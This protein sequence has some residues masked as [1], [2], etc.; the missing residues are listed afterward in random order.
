M[1]THFDAASVQQ[2]FWILVEAL[3]ALILGGM[4]GLEREKVG[5][6][7]G[8]RTHML[9]CVAAMLFIRISQFLIEDTRKVLPVEMLSIDP[10]RMLEAIMAGIAFI[11]AGTVF[12][13]PDRNVMRGLTTAASLLVVVPIGVAV[14]LDR[15]VL[16]VGST[17]LV[18]VV[19]HA[20]R[21][22]EK[23]F[24]LKADGAASEQ[25]EADQPGAAERPGRERTPAA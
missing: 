9:V 19:L 22:L 6:F 20:M 24:N 23:T 16:A 12:R 8:F 10:V 11:G 7:A 21:R 1:T 5:N 15:Y 3:I 25:R 17:A 4:I 18:L 13:D 14:A 2:E